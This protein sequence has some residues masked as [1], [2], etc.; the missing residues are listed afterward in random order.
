M[1]RRTILLS[2]SAALAGVALQLGTAT[3][4]K[5]GT[6]AEITRAIPETRIHHNAFS[7]NEV[8]LAAMNTVQSDCSPGPIPD[9]RVITPPTGGKHR[10]EEITIPIDRKPDNSRAHCN[11]KPVQAFGVFYKSNDGFTG[12]DKI[13]LDVDF[14]SGTVRRFVYDI[15]VR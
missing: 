3:A 1:S 5:A 14:K 11:G 9:V 6:K 7:G 2:L 13:V 15:S 10:L 8:R 12:R 4:Q